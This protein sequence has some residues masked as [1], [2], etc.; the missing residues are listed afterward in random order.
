MLGSTKRSTHE[1]MIKVLASLYMH[2]AALHFDL[3][4]RSSQ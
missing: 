3:P 2:L 1:M 4:S